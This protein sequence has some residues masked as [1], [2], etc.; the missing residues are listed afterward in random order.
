MLETLMAILVMAA[1]LLVLAQLVGVAIQN[2]ARARSGS[3]AI[4]VAQGQLEM[5]KAQ[6][7]RQLNTGVP[8][9][10]LAATGDGQYHTV[11]PL[12]L[13]DRLF[14]VRWSV[15]DSAGARKTVTVESVEVT[16]VGTS[17]TYEDPYR[18]QT[19][20]VRVISQFAP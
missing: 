3:V 9:A 7:Y 1:G 20:L 8:E 19:K 5:L 13:G 2:N 18:R 16:R 14:R 17:G 11:A 4:A 12:Q 10:D 15:Q 6:Y